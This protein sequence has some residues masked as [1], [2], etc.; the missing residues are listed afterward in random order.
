V[1]G[2][3]AGVG[4]DLRTV[5]RQA[6]DGMGGEMVLEVDEQCKGLVVVGG[7]GIAAG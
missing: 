1:I 3:Q 4:G 7:R 6:L 5:V 2:H